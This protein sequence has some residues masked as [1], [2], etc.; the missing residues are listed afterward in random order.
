MTTLEMEDA[1]IEI[2]LDKMDGSKLKD[3]YPM[4]Y[5]RLIA[6]IKDIQDNGGIVDVP[7]EIP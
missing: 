7:S 4:Q 5:D 3:K 1:I 2:T 6:Q